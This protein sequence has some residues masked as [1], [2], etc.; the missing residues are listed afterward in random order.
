MLQGAISL[1]IDVRAEMAVVRLRS[2][3]DMS[4]ERVRIG[5]ASD[6]DR[7]ALE[8]LLSSSQRSAHAR[9]MV[10]RSGDLIVG[11]GSIE[12]LGNDALLDN[13]AVAATHRNRSIG[14]TLVSVLLDAAAES[15]AANVY[16]ISRGTEGFFRRLH[17]EEMEARAAEA[18]GIQACAGASVFRVTLAVRTRIATLMRERVVRQ[19][20][21]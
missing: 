5:P 12:P 6:Q 15:G 21:A 7:A 10:A 16:T 17:W 8:Q 3:F 4:N 13:L 9:W 2:T 11:C 19:E 20:T 18:A 1:S 14:S